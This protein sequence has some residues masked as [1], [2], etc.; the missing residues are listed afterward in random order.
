ME[1]DPVAYYTTIFT[2]I[3]TAWTDDGDLVETWNISLIIHE[4]DCLTWVTVRDHLTLVYLAE[5]HGYT[6][7]GP[8]WSDT[9]LFMSP[10]QAVLHGCADWMDYYGD[11]S[12]WLC[13]PAMFITREWTALLEPNWGFN[14]TVITRDQAAESAHYYARA[15]YHAA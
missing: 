2:T 11:Y 14:P 4:R 8:R 3:S 5:Q 6:Y 10:S 13:I 12:R 7:I 15:C 1:N 9:G